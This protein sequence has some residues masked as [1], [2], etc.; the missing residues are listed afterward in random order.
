MY[1]KRKKNP[2]KCPEKIKIV[3]TIGTHDAIFAITKVSQKDTRKEGDM[4]KKNELESVMRKNGDT[5]TSLSKYLGIA[6]STFSAKINENGAEFNK[7]EIGAIINRYKLT[8][9]EVV[10]IFFVEKVSQKDT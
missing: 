5:G 7:K 6:R 3:L 4:M 1:D 10:N 9:A 2:K 8:P